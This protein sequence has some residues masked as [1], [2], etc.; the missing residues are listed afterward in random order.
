MGIASMSIPSYSLYTLNFSPEM[1]TLTYVVW[2]QWHPLAV[3]AA[4]LCLQTEGPLV[5]RAWKVVDA[6]FQQYSEI[7]ADTK[8][9]MLW[10][11]IQK[12]MKKAKQNRR[13]AQMA[14]LGLGNAD[15]DT[16]MQPLP[17]TA[18]NP[19]PRS[20]ERGQTTSAE[21]NLNARMD[22]FAPLGVW[23]DGILGPGSIGPNGPLSSS[24][25]RPGA[26]TPTTNWTPDG[27]L[28]DTA[29]S[30]SY[31]EPDNLMDMSWMNWEGF[32]GDMNVSDLE[33]PDSAGAPLQYP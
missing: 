32:L 31:Q 13:T 10:Q 17:T 24:N 20:P 21:R 19:P 4:E 28:F 33:I 14:I 29:D 30:N 1:L 11:P 25:D 18:A 15:Q 8:T 7:V 9:G 12:L 6:A 23:G 22:T 27:F 5:E 16:A 26:P 2:V 3:A